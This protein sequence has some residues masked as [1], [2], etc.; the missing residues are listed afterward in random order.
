[1]TNYMGEG[2]MTGIFIHPLHQFFFFLICVIC[3]Q[4]PI[5]YARSLE[6]FHPVEYTDSR[7][8]FL[9]E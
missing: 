2:K 3:G 1:M 8:F 6:V 7:R 9:F 5:K 4:S